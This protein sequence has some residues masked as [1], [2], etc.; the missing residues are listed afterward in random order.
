MSIATVSLGE[1]SHSIVDGP[2]GSSLKTSDYVDDGI[3][4]LQGKNITGDRFAWKEVRYITLIKAKELARSSCELGD[5]L[6]IKI[7]SIGYSAI[8]D[9]LKGH[10]FAIIPAN[11]ARI[12]PNRRLIDDRYLHH[13]LISPE[14][15][16][17]FIGVA[18]KT[19]QPALSL[20]KIK[21]ARLPLPPLDEQRRIAAILDKAD[22][23]RRKRKLAIELLDSVTQS[24]FG[25][26]ARKDW[27][28]A[29]VDNFVTWFAVV[30]LDRRV[31][32]AFLAA[33]S[34][35]L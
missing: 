31:I 22:A 34:Q 28:I 23:L 5:H 2:F 3:P 10:N 14:A 20:T 18:S 21:E 29:A 8:L 7:G 27:P 24:I 30:R 35:D 15:K 13:W 32:L 33:L 11:L 1:V 4:V 26:V 12:R 16:R 6:I 19:A 25:E 17:Y 9:D